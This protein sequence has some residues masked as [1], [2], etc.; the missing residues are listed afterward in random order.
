MKKLIRLAAVL[1]IALLLPVAG[2]F[3]ETGTLLLGGESD[4]PQTT[5][6]PTSSQQSTGGALGVLS[7]GPGGN[8]GAASSPAPTAAS[9]GK[10]IALTFD[11]GPTAS[12]T[13]KLLDMLKKYGVR[14]TFFVVGARIKG[15]EALLRRMVDE[16]H[17]IGSHTYGHKRLTSL[18]DEAIE[19]DLIRTIN[20][21]NAACGVTPSMVRPPYG[22]KNARVLACLEQMGL[23]CVMWN[24]DPEDWNASSARAVRDHV[25]ARAEN[26][27]IV[28]MPDLR[29]TSVKAAELIIQALTAKGY[30]FVT[31]S[32][33]FSGELEAGVAYRHA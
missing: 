14:A 32:E 29:S 24:I 33:L 1:L 8:A 19:K 16:G 6:A 3:A 21:V 28:L 15:N 13:P 22:A 20:L 17:E 7:G 26:G 30:A 23:A 5:P 25:V 27:C 10:Y 11:D 4:Q 2:A 31:V 9:G 18:T 12:N